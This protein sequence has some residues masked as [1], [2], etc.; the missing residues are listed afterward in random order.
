[1]LLAVL[2]ACV[3]PTV[4]AY[5]PD[6]YCQFH[7]LGSL[8]GDASLNGPANGATWN[9]YNTTWLLKNGNV[10][11]ID[12][13]ERCA[14]WMVRNDVGGNHAAIVTRQGSSV[15]LQGF[16]PAGPLVPFPFGAMT[17]L[18]AHADPL[19]KRAFLMSVIEGEG[20][21]CSPRGG[22]CFAAQISDNSRSIQGGTN[23]GYY[24]HVA[25]LVPVAT[26]AGVGSAYT[27]MA[28]SC[29]PLSLLQMVAAAA[30]CI[31]SQDFL[32]VSQWPVA[33][34]DR[35]PGFGHLAGYV[36]GR[37]DP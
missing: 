16:W 18:V 29:T 4:G 9:P 17:P 22:L 28:H 21:V 19:Q 13:F 36:C 10:H 8:Y 35:V 32:V 31:R 3:G 37:P 6:P 33:A 11:V 5:N 26:A 14:R 34:C 1:V 30:L 2:P 27:A 12:R 7:V 24:Q 23:P 15:T 25:A 20:E